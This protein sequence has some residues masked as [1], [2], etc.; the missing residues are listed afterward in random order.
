LQSFLTS[1]NQ[2]LYEDL[3]YEDLPSE[4]FVT[5]AVGILDPEEATLDLISAGHGPLLFYLSAEDRFRSYDAQ[6]LPLGLMPHF[7]YGSPQKLTF[8]RGDILV[9]GTDGFV[10]WANADEEDF[11][12]KRLKEV[13]KANRG[14]PS[15]TI[16]SELYAAVSSFAGP[17]PQLDDLTALV[18]KRL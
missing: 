3:P 10:E 8:A 16:I 2:L 4:R 6:G 7:K 11:G 17:S 5:M 18:V 12:Q 13:I 9:F 1:L 15:A 14:M